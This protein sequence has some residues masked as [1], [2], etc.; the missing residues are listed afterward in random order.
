MIFPFFRNNRIFA[1][2]KIVTIN[3]INIMKTI[4]IL[5]ASLAALL[6]LASCGSKKDPKVDV[7]LPTK[8]TV[9][10]V[11]YMVG[12]NFGYFI[13]ANGFGTDLNYGEIKK[14]MMDFIN[15][16]GNMRDEDF[17]KQF[18]IN[19]DEMNRLFD[20]YITALREY[21]GAVNKVKGEAFLAEKFNETGVAKTESGLLYQ[22]LEEGNDVKAAE[23]DTV[24]VNYTGTLIDGTEF[25]SNKNA[26]E[27][28]QM[29]VDN[30]IPGFK[31][32]LGLVG[33][34]GKIKLYIP[35]DLAYGE[36]GSRGAI[37]P[38][39]A[40]I[41]DIEVTKVGKYVE[42]APEPAKKKK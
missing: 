14:G 4:K 12:F 13:K 28:V 23:K 22:I 25:D 26:G 33:E 21:N 6:L 29:M 31:E 35:S 34:G 41:F 15:A 38:N 9:D 42:P 36:R 7:K 37:E 39:S 16:K 3:F 30:V 5:A 10:S 40:L 19:P 20:E 24:W 8:A 17:N 1:V 32:G 2:L 11:S 27:P 18:K